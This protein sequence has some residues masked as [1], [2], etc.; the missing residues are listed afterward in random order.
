MPRHIYR[1]PRRGFG[2]VSDDDLLAAG[3]GGASRQADLNDF[4]AWM[5]TMSSGSSFVPNPPQGSAMI[6]NRYI[7]A[8]P[9]TPGFMEAT[10][11]SG[12]PGSTVATTTDPLPPPATTAPSSGM[13]DTTFYAILGGGI[14]VAGVGM[15]LLARR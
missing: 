14:L 7:K 15:A 5:A 3:S 6:D 2:A 8:P 4:N 11:G 12:V 1:Q 9:G 10:V 13:S